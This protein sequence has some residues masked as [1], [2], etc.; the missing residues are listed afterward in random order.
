MVR[1][2]AVHILSI[3]SSVAYGHVGNQAA[4]FPLQRLGADVTAIN[5]VAFSN[6]PG[7]GAFAGAI[8]KPDTVQALLD[9]VAARGILHT[10]DAL[11]SGYLGDAGTGAVVLD[12]A[13]RLRLA[14]PKAL[15]CCDPVIG[16]DAPGIYTRPGI[17]DFFRNQAVAAADLLTPNRFELACLTGLPCV[18]IADVLSALS[19]L[20]SAMRA[21]GP[22]IVL[23]TSVHTEDTPNDAIDCLAAGGQG[24]FRLRTPKLPVSVNGAGDAMAAVFL[25]HVLSTSDVRQ[26]LEKSAASIHGLLSRTFLAGSR[27]LRLVAAQDEFFHPSSHFN[28]HAL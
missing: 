12:A 18:T 8:L 25:F 19:A 11:L 22:R 20:R 23:V 24:V 28:A 9:G 6:H 21:D 10:C 26:A 14:N 2:A 17:A 13:R 7:Y 1:A 3:Q 15:W 27:E 16:D 4:V 5:T